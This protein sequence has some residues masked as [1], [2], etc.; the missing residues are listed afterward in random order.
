MG[1]KTQIPRVRVLKLCIALA[2][3]WRKELAGG[4]SPRIQRNDDLHAPKGRRSKAR[5]ELVSPLQ[6]LTVIFSPDTGG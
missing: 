1:E 5:Q 6:G 2:T 3:E 4:V